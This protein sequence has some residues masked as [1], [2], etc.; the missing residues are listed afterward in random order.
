[1]G[2]QENHKGKQENHDVCLQKLQ[3]SNCWPR[4]GAVR[5]GGAGSTLPTKA[6]M[7]FQSKQSA[8]N[9]N[10]SFA[11]RQLLLP[12]HLFHSSYSINS[13][14]LFS[15][16]E[17]KWC[18]QPSPFHCLWLISAK[19]WCWLCLWR[20]SLAVQMCYLN[21]NAGNTFVSVAFHLL[22]QALKLWGKKAL[23]FPEHHCI[24]LFSQV[25]LLHLKSLL[26]HPHL[27]HF[28]YSS[29]FVIDKLQACSWKLGSF[30]FPC[31]FF[32]PKVLIVI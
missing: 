6:Q 12:R 15:F 26:M 9:F 21:Y 17:N 11:H 14:S 4:R 2:K 10:E 32:F 7:F 23:F 22:H 20:Y 30:Q 29:V 19:H 8:L 3:T 1:M 24:F 27:V 13:P 5:A 31:I 18:F 28:Y 25:S 16:K